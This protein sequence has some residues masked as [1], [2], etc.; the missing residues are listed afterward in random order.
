MFADA[1]TMSINGSAV[2]GAEDFSVI[3]PATAEPFASAPN[4]TPQELD[5][6]INAARQA[7]QAWGAMSFEERKPYV[8]GL[9]AKI[10]ENAEPLASLLTKEQGK[11]FA[12]AMA[13]VMGGAYWLSETVKLDLPEHVSEES[14]ERRAVTRYEPIGVVAGLVPWNFPIILAMFKVA[15]ALFAGNTMVL[16]PAP[17]TPLTTLRI[18]ELAREVLPPGVLNVVSGDDRLG[19]WLTAH[20]GIDKVSFTGSTETGKRVMASAAPDLKRIT[21]ELGGNDAAIVM[22]D[23][24]VE[25]VVK[26]LFWAAFKNAGQICIATKR[27]YIHEDIYEPLSEAIADYART[28]KVGDG[29]QQGSQIGPVQNERQYQRVLDLIQDAKDQGYEFLVGGDASEAPG[30]FIPVTILD[31][32]PESARI[33][34]EEQFGPVLP[35]MKFSDL[36]EVIDRANASEYGLGASVWSPDID[37]AEEIAARIKA[38]TIWINE[39]QHL[40]PHAAF[41]GKKQSGIGVEGGLDGLME[42]TSAKT[43]FTRYRPAEL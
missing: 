3:N 32:P 27:M 26:N 19:P 23:V 2:A 24:D 21:L 14:E 39:S 12:D 37:H 9:A 31:N 18:G 16:K 29:S 34:Q 6:A 30:Y 28:V 33:V 20:P 13:D 4:C 35:L 43:V 17:T 42:F 15:P 36:D 38:G 5:D 8:L 41:G 40:S 10:A 11:P 25:L 7:Q 22:P 1:Y